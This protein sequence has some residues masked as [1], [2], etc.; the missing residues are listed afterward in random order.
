MQIEYNFLWSPIL[1]TLF[2][3]LELVVFFLSSEHTTRNKKNRTLEEQ[4]F[5]TKLVWL[6]ATFGRLKGE[7]F[8]EHMLLW[9]NLLFSE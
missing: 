7:A 3:N 5:D 4:L 2:L 8:L 1:A 9:W 6:L